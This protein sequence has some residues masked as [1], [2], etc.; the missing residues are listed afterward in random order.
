[1]TVRKLEKTQWRPYFDRVS[2]FLIG[3]R[4]EIEVES[5]ALG[6]QIE[7]EWLPLLGITYDPKNDLLEIELENLDHMI[8]APQAVY[9]DDSPPGLTSMEVVDRDGI[10]Q[11]I[12]LR[13]PL[14]LPPPSAAA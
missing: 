4:A 3:K 2:E 7:A 12:R 6:A 13:D 11:I 8:R 9:I 5:L 1:M 10:Q 14:M